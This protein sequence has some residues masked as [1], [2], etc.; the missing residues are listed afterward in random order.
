MNN[1]IN[2][3]GENSHATQ[4]NYGTD[5]TPPSPARTLLDVVEIVSRHRRNLMLRPD[6]AAEFDRSLAL[7]A[8]AAQHGNP[9]SAPALA[10][11]R[12]VAATAGQL[13]LGAG[14]E[15]LWM[16]FRTLIGHQ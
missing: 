5:P 11:G 13:I 10:A 8:N 15:H 9:H 6:E 12:H 16:A 4:N 2:Q 1:Y 7:L 3:Y 14:G